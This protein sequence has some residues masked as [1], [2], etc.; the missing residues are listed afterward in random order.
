MLIIE[1]FAPGCEPKYAQNA[2][3]PVVR[4]DPS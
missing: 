3:P 1:T 4:I 2:T